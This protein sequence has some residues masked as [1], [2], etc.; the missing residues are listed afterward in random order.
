MA[1]DY[2]VSKLPLHCNLFGDSERVFEILCKSQDLKDLKL[3]LRGVISH[4]KREPISAFEQD[5]LCDL[6]NSISLISLK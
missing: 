2:H 6:Y 1:R 5:V 3:A 4:G